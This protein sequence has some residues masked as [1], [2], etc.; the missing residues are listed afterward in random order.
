[1]NLLKAL[2]NA[3]KALSKA[4]SVELV[5]PLTAAVQVPV[6]IKPLPLYSQ[7]PALDNYSLALTLL[8]INLLLSPVTKYTV[9][10]LELGNLDNLNNL[11]TEKNIKDT[12]LPI[13][14]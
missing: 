12:I 14:D 5:T 10:K 13:V 11:N 2:S 3:C 9:N 6:V 4:Q 7:R 8:L 1:M